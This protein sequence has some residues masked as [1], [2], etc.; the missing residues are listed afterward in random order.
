MKIITTIILSIVLTSGF[1]Q[2]SLFVGPSSQFN[3]F[4]ENEQNLLSPSIGGLFGM[5]FSILK[6]HSLDVS[7]N[8]HWSRHRNYNFESS[9]K[10]TDVIFDLRI[11]G[12]FYL[13]KKYPNIFVAP[14]FDMRYLR[15][16]KYYSA[17]SPEANNRY[18]EI[19]PFGTC[20]L[21]GNFKLFEQ[22][23]SFSVVYG[24]TNWT[25]HYTQFGQLNILY[26]FGNKKK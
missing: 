9:Q 7:L 21:G 26:H 8:T 15:V 16:L 12:R 23:C 13:L 1:S 18:F 4:W 22:D 20:S 10:T 25:Y 6:K 3:Y 5:Q 19:A 17:E 14:G 2:I 11:E 24:I